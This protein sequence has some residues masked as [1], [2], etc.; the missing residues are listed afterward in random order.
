MDWKAQRLKSSVVA[1][2]QLK[3]DRWHQG[4]ELWWLTTVVVSHFYFK[5]I[6]AV[7]CVCRRVITHSSNR[8]IRCVYTY[9]P[10]SGSTDSEPNWPVSGLTTWK[11]WVSVVTSVSVNVP[12]VDIDV[13]LTPRIGASLV[14]FIV[15]VM[16]WGVPS[17]EWIVTVSVKVSPV[18][19]PEL[20]AY[21]YQCNSSSCHADLFPVAPV[22]IG[23][24]PIQVGQP[25]SMF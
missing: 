15:M 23:K 11:V 7:I 1:T 24:V 21:G 6:G 2:A 8:T 12:V 13:W 25:S 19:K 22:S 18:P 9:A 14:P 10:E 4:D 20:Q 17:S 3:H 16:T 5:H